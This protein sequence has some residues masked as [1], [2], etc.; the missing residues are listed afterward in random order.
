[1]IKSTR[2]EMQR[3]VE[4]GRDKNAYRVS[5][6]K[7]EEKRLLGRLRSIWKDNIKNKQRASVRIGS[8]GLGLGIGVV[9]S[10]EHFHK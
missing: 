3:D 5:V 7:L 2:L 10:C 1:M 4:R 9:D 8:I 6:G